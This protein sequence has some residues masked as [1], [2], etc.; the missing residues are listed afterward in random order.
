MAT[1]NELR[2]IAEAA[3]DEEQSWYLLLSDASDVENKHIAA[4]SPARAL[5]ACDLAEAARY[6]LDSRGTEREMYM[7]DLRAAVD[8]W[9]A[10]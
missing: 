5:A 6:V 7:R 2:A 10:L 1:T 3:D 9:E 8:A 4:W